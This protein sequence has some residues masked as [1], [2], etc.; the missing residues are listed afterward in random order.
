MREKRK[1]TRSE[2]SVSA[3][4]IILGGAPVPVQ[5]RNISLGGVLLAPGDYTPPRPASTVE[6]VVRMPGGD[7]ERRMMARVSRADA[8]GVALLFQ[9]FDL[10][11]FGF[12]QRLLAQAKRV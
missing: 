12:L 3:Q 4:L 5:T 8:T 11:D 9:E 1:Q 7:E 2:I 10:D 6:L